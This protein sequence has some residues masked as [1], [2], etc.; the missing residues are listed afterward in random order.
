MGALSALVL[1]A[2]LAG[3]TAGTA[4]PHLLAPKLVVHPLPDGNVTVYVHSAFGERPYDRLDLLLENA[5]VATRTDAFS[6]ETKVASSGFFAEVNAQAEQET[7]L[8]RARIDIDPLEKR[9][10]VVVLDDKGVWGEPQTYA[11]PYERIIER[12]SG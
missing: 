6:L 10:R 1:C 8:L 9:V 4:N 11:L 7:Y 12:V 3:C 5:T 2:L